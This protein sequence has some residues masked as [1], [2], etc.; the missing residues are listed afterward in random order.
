MLKIRFTQGCNIVEI[1]RNNI[2]EDSLQQ[3]LDLDHQKELKVFFLGEM[4]SIAQ[5]AGGMEKE[6][7]NL[8]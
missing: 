1:H 3:F 5:D 2:F 7:F 8:I 6:W 4:S